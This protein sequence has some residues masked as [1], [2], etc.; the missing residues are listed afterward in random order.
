MEVKISGEWA[1]HENKLENVETV[2]SGGEDS[3]QRGRNSTTNITCFALSERLGYMIS[4]GLSNQHVFDSKKFLIKLWK[5]TFRL[6]FH[7]YCSVLVWFCW[8]FF[9]RLFYLYPHRKDLLAVFCQNTFWHIV[10]TG[11]YIF[12]VKIGDY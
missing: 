1:Q 2:P 5:Q 8:V 11:K 6:L 12:S 3:W 4:T 9:H 7:L 10:A